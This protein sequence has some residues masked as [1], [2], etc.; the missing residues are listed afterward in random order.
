M[1]ST[2]PTI[3]FSRFLTGSIEDRRRVASEVDDALKTAG[4]F[5]LQ[6]HGI[7]QRKIDECLTAVGRFF[8]FEP[9]YSLE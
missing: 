5:Q 7:P 9:L 8:Y 6:N 1:L 4:S 3:D 2:L